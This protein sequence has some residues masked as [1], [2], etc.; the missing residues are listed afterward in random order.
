VLHNVVQ[1]EE[2]CLFY[3]SILIRDCCGVLRA[4]ALRKISSNDYSGATVTEWR[5]ST[6]QHSS[7]RSDTGS[8]CHVPSNKKSIVVWKELISSFMK[9]GV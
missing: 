3:K 4:R 6:C 5:N 7:V 2:D 1:N 9:N 8:G